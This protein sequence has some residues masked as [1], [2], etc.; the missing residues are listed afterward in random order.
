MS[1]RTCSWLLPQK[2][3]RYGT[4]GPLLP[5]VEV[6]CRS[7]LPVCLFALRAL[8][9][10]CLLGASLDGRLCGLLVVMLRRQRIP[11][12]RIDRIDDAIVLRILGSHEVVPVG[13]LSHLVN[14]LARVS[15][16]DF[17]V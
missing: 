4:L 14:G 12:F 8:R 17:D 11:L 3:Q 7:L 10:R 13:V 9:L 1:F 2:E 6:T 16:K 15:S 5:L